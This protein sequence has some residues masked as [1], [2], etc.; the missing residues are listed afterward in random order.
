M[1]AAIVGLQAYDLWRSH[2]E[3]AD[4]GERDAQNVLQTL[5]T[6]IERNLYLLD[7]SLEGAQEVLAIPGLDDLA[8]EVRNRMLFDRAAS[9]SYV[10]GMIVLDAQGHV[11]YEAGSTTPHSGTYSDR[12]YFRA[13][14]APGRETFVS[15]PFE[16]RISNGDPSIALSRRLPGAEGPFEGVVAAALRIAYF[17]ALFDSVRLPSGS[18]LVLQ[19]TDGTIVLREPSTDG[20]GNIG[21]SIAQVPG[22]A[23]TAAGAEE[24]RRAHS[25][26]D[27]VERLYV[28]RLVGA[29]PLVLTVGWS[30][31][32]LFADWYQRAVIT[33]FLTLAVCLV[34]ALTVGALRK[35]LQRSRDMESE[36]ESMATTDQLTGLPNRR[37][38]DAQ[39]AEE[40]RRARRDGSPLALLMVDIDHF[41]QVNDTHGHAAGDA[42]LRV[43]ADR[44]TAELRRPGDFAGRFGGEEF[45]VILPATPV[46]GARMRAERIRSLM[47]A[48]PIG[49]DG[50][51][52]RLTVSVGIALSSPA[53]SASELL[54]RADAALYAAKRGGRNR[55]VCETDPEFDLTAAVA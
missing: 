45:V 53:D 36:L 35:A 42:A 18:I 48:S 24:M 49:T 11:R 29:F 37:A 10:G 40:L 39:L 26:L 47:E 34:L 22:L 16:S 50:A 23:E 20:R 44:I 3:I 31:P 2:G 51:D 41:K 15:G 19:L 21:T 6:A 1:I 46:E 8:P 7:L 5:S 33:M 14:R 43:V 28:S 25:P 12:A 54:T 30:L 38:L 17:R 9:A 27:G 32:T 13:L 55:V 4:D 52:M